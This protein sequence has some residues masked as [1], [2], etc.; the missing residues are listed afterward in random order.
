[1]GR[2]G[3]GRCD[4]GKHRRCTRCSSS[5]AVMEGVT[6]AAFA[7]IGQLAA[8]HPGRR[9]TRGPRPGVSAAHDERPTRV[10]RLA[11]FPAGP[12]RMC[13]CKIV[14][15]VMLCH[16]ARGATTSLHHTSSA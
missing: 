13:R 15:G 3:R 9:G 6:A 14:K 8:R 7:P 16:S 2:A 11:H 5:D 10:V 12:S 1:V 4:A